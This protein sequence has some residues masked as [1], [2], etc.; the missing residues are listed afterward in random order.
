[1]TE[2][3]YSRAEGYLAQLRTEKCKDVY[4]KDIKF[5]GDLLETPSKSLSDKDIIRI[6]EIWDYMKE[7]RYNRIGRDL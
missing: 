3:R 5:I 4:L 1:M 7:A 6:E 2:Q